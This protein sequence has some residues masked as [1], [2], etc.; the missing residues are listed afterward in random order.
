[1]KLIAWYK[2]LRWEITSRNMKRDAQGWL[3][4]IN[5]TP[6]A[7]PSLQEQHREYTEQLWRNKRRKVSQKIMNLCQHK[8]VRDDECVDCGKYFD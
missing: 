4:E 2:V 1:M 3:S 6:P 7:N 8:I 5:L